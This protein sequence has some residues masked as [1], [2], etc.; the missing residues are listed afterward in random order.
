[1]QLAGLT[2]QQYRC[3]LSCTCRSIWNAKRDKNRIIIFINKYTDS[4]I[5]KIVLLIARIDLQ[6]DL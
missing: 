5:P 6:N 3:I 1:M 2:E 4:L